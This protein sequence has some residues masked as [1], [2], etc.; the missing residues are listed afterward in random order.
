MIQYV[1]IFFLL[2][3]SLGFAN[4]KQ[5]VQLLEQGSPAPCTG[6]L[7]SEDA[8]K[9]AAEDHADTIFYKDL[10]LRLEKRKELTDKEIQILDK[11]LQLYISQSELLAERLHKT[12]TRSQWEKILW[13]GMGIFVTGL[14]VHGASQL[15]N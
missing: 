13:F 4:C 8:D 6:L 14:A 1:L 9:Q 2:L 12:E 3:P 7:Y 5:P 11:R 10:T 15:A